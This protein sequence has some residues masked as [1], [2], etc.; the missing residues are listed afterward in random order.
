MGWAVDIDTPFDEPDLNSLPVEC[1]DLV[2]GYVSRALQ[3]W[4]DAAV[5]ADFVSAFFQRAFFDDDD[6]DNQE[7]DWGPLVPDLG[8]FTQSW[9]DSKA[10]A[11]AA[12]YAADVASCELSRGYSLYSEYGLPHFRAFA[13]GPLFT[14]ALDRVDQFLQFEQR[15]RGTTTE[16]EELSPELRDE[17]LSL[18]ERASRFP[19]EFYLTRD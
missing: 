5:A 16:E 15:L 1:H 12:A 19:G 9:D 6:L 10:S 2:V 8:D 17:Y 3:S 11:L 14:E 4:T 18:V 7:L 13:W